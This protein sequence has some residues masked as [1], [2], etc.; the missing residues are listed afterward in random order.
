VKVEGSTTP[1]VAAVLNYT[2]SRG[3]RHYDNWL[4][5]V[6]RNFCRVDAEPAEEERIDW[7]IGVTQMASISFAQVGGSS[8]RFLRTR[9]LLSDSRD[10]FVLM[11]A[12]SGDMIV[13]RGGHE[14]R[15]QESQMSL[16]DLSVE[17][18]IC[19]VEGHRFQSTRIPRAEL[20]T[21]CP[22]AENRL[23]T[24]IDEN[25]QI[26]ELIAQYSTLS[27]ISAASLDAVGQQAVARHLVDLI[28]LLLRTGRETTHLATERGYA[29][30][31][32]R[33]VQQHVL[34]HLSEGDLAVGS[35][36]QSCG[37]SPKQ[38]QRLFERAGTTFTE[39]VLEQR[40]LLA[41][42]LLASPGNR[43]DKIGTIAYS[44]GFGDLSYF[45]RAF[46]GRFDMTPSEWRN[47]QPDGS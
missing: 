26:R 18:G 28:A 2:G 7:K 37:L 4:E 29:A 12:I 38:V 35:I 30:A 6:C 10:D 43:Q 9:N 40:L 8:G 24:L 33:S 45:N 36:A 23:Y 15:L 47:I 31:R 1:P 5:G 44:A 22:D 25:Q 39:F 32:L 27:A 3:G 21:M 14:V 11:T 13:T 20:L 19:V 42:R 34:Q 16:M 46:R 41:R 17:G